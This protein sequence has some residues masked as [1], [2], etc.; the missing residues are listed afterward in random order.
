MRAWRAFGAGDGGARATRR[1]RGPVHAWVVLAALLLLSGR[2]ALAQGV[3]LTLLDGRAVVIDGAQR[4]EAVAGMRPAA[5]AI[6]ET[7]A[8][9]GLVRLEWPDGSVVDLG[10]ETK[11]MIQPPGFGARSGR[12]PL[13]YLLQGWA[14]VAGPGKDPA[15]GVLTPSFE[16]LPFIGAAV[17]YSDRRERFAFPESA[18]I[19]IV[20]RSAAGKRHGVAA[21]AL[22]A[23]AAGVL[24]RPTADWLARVPRAFRDPLPLRAAAYKDRIVTASA[25]AAPTYVGLADWLTAEP[26]VRRDFPQRFVAL[27]QDAESRRALQSHLSSHPEWG[28]VL[29]PPAE[30]A[31]NKRSR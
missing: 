6:V 25:L 27:A 20:E 3:I 16:L 7:A 18:P 19:E 1:A 31:D 11:A 4:L 15:G 13:L 30:R 5:A 21:G 28:P 17:V 9:T 8:S 29:N 14:K 12:L 2:A 10:P 23:G 24:P 26:A 22:Y